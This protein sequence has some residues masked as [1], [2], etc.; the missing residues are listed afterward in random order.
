M[1]INY[2]KSVG[3]Y[4]R[5]LLEQRGLISLKKKELWEILGI[6][7]RHETFRKIIFEDYHTSDYSLYEELANS[8]EIDPQ[9]L[10][11]LAVINLAP[12]KISP[13]LAHIV[14]NLRQIDK[15]KKKIAEWTPKSLSEHTIALYE[16]ANFSF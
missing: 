16:I 8:L 10:L 7:K 6:S 9:Q 15:Y 2:E 14:T 12:E 1:E 5:Q 4:I 3:A 13:N 11:L